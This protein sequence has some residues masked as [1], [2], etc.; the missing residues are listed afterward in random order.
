MLPPRVWLIAVAS[1]VIL[2]AS[3]G[4]DDGG[5]TSPS[6]SPSRT[7]VSVQALVTPVG[8]PP[9]VPEEAEAVSETTTLGQIERQANQPPRGIETR[10]LEDAFC[11]NDVIVFQTS[12]E[13]IYTAR[14]C[15]GFWSAKAAP[16]FLD[17]EIAVV[18]E[19]TERRFAVLI[20]SLAGAQAEFTVGGIWVE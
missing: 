1:L 6:L 5:V 15:D 10:R 7:N 16:A 3:C 13:T 18:L 2:A 4:S 20:E 17:Q 19:V 8:K 12:K 9:N 14:N 11:E